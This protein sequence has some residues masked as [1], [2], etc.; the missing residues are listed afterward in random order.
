VGIKNF[1]ASVINR[2]KNISKELKLPFNLI[3]QLY[4]QERLLFRLSRS[5]YN[6][7]FLLKG[8]LLLYSMT[9]FKGRPTKDIDFLAKNISN[10]L[11][12]IKYIFKEIC[13]IEGNDAVR[14]DT[15]TIKTQNIKEDAD[16]RGVRL[17]IIAYIGQA[18]VHLQI[19]IGFGD[20][21]IPKPVKIIYPVLLNLESP[22]LNVYSFESV[23]AEKF[24]AMI[25]L[26][27][28]N[29]RMKDF[30][31]IY[32]LLNNR[33]FDGRVL[34]EAFYETFQRRGTI[35]EKDIEIFTHEFMINSN[36]NKQWDI[37]LKRIGKNN[38]RFKKVMEG[39]KKFTWPVYNTILKE[40]EFLYQWDSQKN[41]WI[42]YS[43]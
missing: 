11:K 9:K 15:E 22:E 42:Y 28:L 37:F 23:I 6:N 1:P 33:D 40:D 43:G 38:L 20:T 2:L 24:E 39:I 32:M 26:A 21:V 25:S 16:Y 30:Y 35:L 41:E 19:D 17:K 29:S 34:Q 31:D 14:F 10:D 18:R 27:S 3:L 5:K 8:G 13:S 7:K 12:N 4:V 36:R